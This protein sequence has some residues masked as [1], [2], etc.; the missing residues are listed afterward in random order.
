MAT[1]LA[2][3]PGRS[4]RPLIH[5]RMPLPSEIP[6]MTVAELV[7]RFRVEPGCKFRLKDHDPAWVGTDELRELGKD[8]LKERA[9]EILAKDLA[10]LAAAQDLLYADNRYAL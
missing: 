6:S 3:E 10:D 2:R 9:K 7:E 1:S 8:E 4:C 5:Q